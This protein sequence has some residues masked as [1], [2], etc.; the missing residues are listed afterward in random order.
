MQTDGASVLWCK[1]YCP[2]L[3]LPVIPYADSHCRIFSMWLSQSCDKV[4]PR[5][6]SIRSHHLPGTLVCSIH[7]TA[8]PIDG[9]PHARHA[10]DMDELE[11]CGRGSLGARL[12]NRIFFPKPH[13]NGA[14]TVAVKE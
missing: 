13:G 11:I 12:V 7:I 3:P 2:I 10:A 6:A 9:Q 4:Y 8:E 14:V 1:V 5:R